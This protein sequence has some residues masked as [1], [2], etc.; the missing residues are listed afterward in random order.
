MNLPEIEPLT[1]KVIGCAMAVQKALGNGF[2]EIIYK[3]ALAIEFGFQGIRNSQSLEMN[4]FYRDELIGSRPLDFLVEDVLMLEVKAE[5]QLL[6]GHKAQ[7]INYCEAYNLSDGLL[8][9][10]GAKSLEFKRVYNKYLKVK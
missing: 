1:H 3:R 2:E 7:A 5:E 6:E 10:F 8:I 4:L 9:N